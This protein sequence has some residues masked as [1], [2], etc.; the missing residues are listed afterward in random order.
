MITYAQILTHAEGGHFT[1]FAHLNHRLI[2]HL[3]RNLSSWSEDERWLKDELE[4]TRLHF[5][6]RSA[7]RAFE[8]FGSSYASFIERSVC[9][10]DVDERLICKLYAGYRRVMEADVASYLSGIAHP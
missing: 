10:G 7:A 2:R 8:V 3:C 9:L 1:P 4:N 5:S 6:L